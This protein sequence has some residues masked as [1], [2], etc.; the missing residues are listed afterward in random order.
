[1]DFLETRK[2]IEMEA[3]KKKAEEERRQMEIE[4]RKVAEEEKRRQIE[5]SKIEAA[6]I[7]KEEKKKQIQQDEMK[8]KKANNKTVSLPNIM[9]VSLPN[10]SQ[11]KVLLEL[12]KVNKSINELN[13]INLKQMKFNELNH[14]KNQIDSFLNESNE[15]HQLFEKLQTKIKSF[16]E[17]LD[18]QTI[19]C[20]N[21]QSKVIDFVNYFRPC[22]F[23]MLQ[24]FDCMTIINLMDALDNKE[25]NDLIRKLWRNMNLDINSC[26]NVMI[27]LNVFENTMQ[28]IM[29]KAL[30]LYHVPV[31]HDCYVLDDGYFDVKDNPD[32]LINRLKVL[33]QIVYEYDKKKLIDVIPKISSNSKTKNKEWILDKAGGRT[34]YEYDEH[35]YISYYIHYCKDIYD[36]HEYLIKTCILSH[37]GKSKWKTVNTKGVKEKI[38]K[39][40]R[41]YTLNDLV[42]NIGHFFIVYWESDNDYKSGSDFETKI[43]VYWCDENAKI[44]SFCQFY[45]RTDTR[46]HF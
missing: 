7:A 25:E 17:K 10:I 20:K 34:K 40:V 14:V 39:V 46:S 18:V 33:C 6:K 4:M 11:T 15:I 29:K 42:K 3:M 24:F 37:S 31:S 12:Y 43:A 23:V 28:E 38:W 26:E 21:Q 41:D 19:A 30:D 22:L 35:A 36:L 8:R 2:Q 16:S 44:F 1:M 13:D 5:I 32:Q 9:T 27:R 45:A